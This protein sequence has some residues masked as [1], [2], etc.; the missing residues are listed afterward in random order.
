MAHPLLA[1]DQRIISTV[2]RNPF[3]TANQVNETVQEVGVWTYL[4]LPQREDCMEVNTE[5]SP[6]GASQH[7]SFDR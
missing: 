6:Q 2:T 3:T 4:S 5:D 1:D 7:S